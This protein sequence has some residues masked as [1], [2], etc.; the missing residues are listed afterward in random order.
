MKE[1]PLQRISLPN[2]ETL[3]YRTAGRG[4]K[5]VLMLH[6]NM[7]SSV[8][9]QTTMAALEDDYQFYALDLRGFGDSTCEAPADSL[10]QFAEDVKAFAD[11]VGL[12]TFDVVGWSTGGGI[13]LELAADWPDRVRQVVLLA[14][15]PPT[16]YP[17]FRKDAAGQEIPGDYLTTKEELATDPVQGAPA[18]VAYASGDQTFM[19]AVWDAAIF[20]LVRPPVGDYERYLDA[21]MQQRNLTDVQY[22]L[23]TFNMTDQ[24]T[25]TTPGSGRLALVRGPVLVLHGEKDLVVPPAWGQQTTDLLGD[26]A[27]LVT[28]PNAGHSIMTDAPEAL[29]QVL[30]DHL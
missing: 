6:G 17:F 4:T 2:G 8:S 23:L 29:C 13:A 28:F 12:E 19:R 26:R 30:R 18:L 10:E 3:A 25:A 16:G 15:V 27:T 14:S 11:A 9:W 5:Q 21:V 20:N 22:A 1:Y 24:P 7:S